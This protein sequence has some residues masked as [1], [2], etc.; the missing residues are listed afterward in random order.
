MIL[1]SFFSPLK[2][3]LLFLRNYLIF[4]RF[5]SFY[6]NSFVSFLC[7]RTKQME[8]LQNHMMP[9]DI[10]KDVCFQNSKIYS[11]VSFT[12]FV[13]H[14]SPSQ[15]QQRAFLCHFTWNF[16]NMRYLQIFI[17]IFFVGLKRNSFFLGYE[18]FLY[19]AFGQKDFTTN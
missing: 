11:L 1:T 14:S 16:N 10:A 9:F 6:F 17:R 19:P 12:F 15:I 2:E 7:V 3:I 5:I 13:F 4:F 8:L 18:F